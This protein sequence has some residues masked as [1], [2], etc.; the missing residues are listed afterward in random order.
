MM[1]KLLLERGERV[2]LT[3]LTHRA[4][5]QM[6]NACSELVSRDQLVKIGVPVYDPG[7]QVEQYSRFS[8]SPLADTAG[9]YAIGATPFSLWSRRLA[10]VEFDVVIFDESSQITPAL[11]VLA[12]LRAERFIFVGDHQQLPPVAP[13]VAED[14]FDFGEESASVFEDL[15]H[16][17][18]S[19][20]LTTCYR[21]NAVLCQWP[22]DQFYGGKL[23]PG[24]A[25]A[26]RK[27]ALQRPLHLCEVLRGEPELLCL[28]IDHDERRT[29]APEE[30]EFVVKLVLAWIRAGLEAKA[31]GILV[32]YRRQANRIRRH[33]RKAGI[34]GLDRAITVDTVERFQGSER[35][36]M[37]LSFTASDP[38]FIQRQASFLFQAQRLNVALTRAQAK[39]VLL[40]STGLRETVE[41]LSAEGD[42][43]MA[44]MANLLADTPR[45]DVDALAWPV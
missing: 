39:C 14:E 7:L 24:E 34:D 42:E 31:I 1:V 28:E 33:L 15:R 11:A 18:I 44:L 27:L 6:L 2:L 17:S 16:H 20:M 43:T 4:V 37:I 21:M 38:T 22:S 30:A 29:D 3:A 5:H 23:K 26:D 9:A 8:Q 35:H 40:H 32:P 19:T 13:R 10:D 12:M 25:N 36:A 45:V 41:R